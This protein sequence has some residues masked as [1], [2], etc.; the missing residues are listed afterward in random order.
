MTLSRRLRGDSSF[1]GKGKWPPTGMDPRRARGAMFNGGV[2][3]TVSERASEDL[4]EAV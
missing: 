3:G 4:G 2:A 1:P